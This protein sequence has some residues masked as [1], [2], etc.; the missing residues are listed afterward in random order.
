MNAATAIRDSCPG[1]AY[2]EGEPADAALRSEVPRVGMRYSYYKTDNERFQAAWHAAHCWIENCEYC[3]FLCE[4]GLVIS[5]DACGRVHH[6]DWLG[7][8]GEL[9]GDQ[10][11]VLCPECAW[12]RP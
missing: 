2:A 3:E 12:V 8:K 5:C 6:T 4:Q 7:W 9:H 10:C 1:L 11:T